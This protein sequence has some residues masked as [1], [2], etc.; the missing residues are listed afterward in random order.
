MKKNTLIAIIIG[1]SML[2]IAS[3]VMNIR[4]SDM[5]SEMS[6]KCETLEENLIKTEIELNGVRKSFDTILG[7]YKNTL[8]IIYS[9][10]LEWQL[11]KSEEYT[12]EL[13]FNTGKQ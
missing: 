12:N 6:T 10:D 13:S 11:H 1:L 3:G 2:L 8:A 4:A 9:N 7:K 5:L